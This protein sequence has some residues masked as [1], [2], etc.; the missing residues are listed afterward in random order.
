MEPP[1]RAAVRAEQAGLRHV[2]LMACWQEQGISTVRNRTSLAAY[3]EAFH[4]H[5]VKVRLWGY[6]WSGL[7]CEFVAALR[8]HLREAAG[9]ISGVIVNPELGYRGPRAATADLLMHKVVDCLSEGQDLW[10]SS[11]GHPEGIK[12]FPWSTFGLWGHGSPQLYMDQGMGVMRR[13]LAEYRKHW[14]D[15]GQLIVP[16][17]PL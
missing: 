10:V 5:G 11:F 7:E 17:I 13:G 14:D 3:A 8:L 2:A 16:G 4:Q 6:P 15:E 9:F 12:D 1:E